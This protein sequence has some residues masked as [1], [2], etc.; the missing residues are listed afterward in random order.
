PQ[1][2]VTY[3]GRARHADGSWRW[4]QIT[5]T[6]LLDD[7]S[8]AG[9]ISNA[10]DIT[11]ARMLENRLRHEASHDGLTGLANRA[12]FDE[13]LDD[14]MGPPSHD[15]NVALLAIDL[16]DFK[17]VNDELGHPTGDALLV[18]VAERLR[19]CV[20]AGDTVAR[21]GGDEF[22]V[23]LPGASATTADSIAQRI[24][25]ELV[26]PVL[27]EGHTLR[28]GASV[29]VCTGAGDAHALVREADAAMYAEKDRSRTRLRVG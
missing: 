23:L 29:G 4:L 14:A 28:V 20:R 15:E 21:V 2:S 6:N 22:A 18:A 16:D 19:G 3:H 7:P 8:V 13:R 26:E 9:I 11:E 27:C 25:E 1:G 12:L 17:G 10:R 24:R 5:S